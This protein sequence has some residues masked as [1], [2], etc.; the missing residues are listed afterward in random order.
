[1]LQRFTQIGIP[2]EVPDLN[3]GD[4]THLT[5]SRQI[6][7]VMA[8][9]PE[10]PSPVVLIGS[11][12]GGL[13]AALI[14][15]QSPQVERLVLLAPAFDF[16]THWLPRLGQE[17]LQRWQAEGTLPIQHYGAGCPLPL[18]YGFVQDAEI[19]T[20]RPLRRALPTLILHGKYDDV[21]PFSSSL[22]YAQTRPW[23]RLVELDSDHAL[24]NMTHELWQ[25]IHQFCFETAS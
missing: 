1:M 25:A 3:Q 17:T 7:Q 5:L 8:L 9:F 6:Q 4:F 22:T 13:T 21:I 10:A 18:H 2:L 23:V 12:L 14:A 15:E 16:L 24:T 19:Y 11:S 20:D